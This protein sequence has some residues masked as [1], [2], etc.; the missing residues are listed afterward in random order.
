MQNK[1]LTCIPATKHDICFNFK[2][3]NQ[4]VHVV[5][6]F[7]YFP[8]KSFLLLAFKT[9]SICISQ[10]IAPIYKNRVMRVA[11]TY[12]QSKNT[13]NPRISFIRKLQRGIIHIIF[14]ASF[15]PEVVNGGLACMGPERVV[16]CADKKNANIPI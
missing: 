7:A 3:W 1:V 5:C 13:D 12:S 9:W 16:C 11:A 14:I 10:Q 8:H 6:I 4:T 15:T 2:A